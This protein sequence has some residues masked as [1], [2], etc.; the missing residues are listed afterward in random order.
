MKRIAVLFIGIMCLI[1][2][3]VAESRPVAE[4]HVQVMPRE[5]PADFNFK[6]RYGYGEANKNEINT[7]IRFVRIWFKTELGWPQSG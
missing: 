2:G 1:T 7:L 4:A 5:M 6:V 3:C